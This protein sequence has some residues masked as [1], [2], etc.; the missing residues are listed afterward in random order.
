MTSAL[1]AGVITE[2]DVRIVFGGAVDWTKI[3]AGLRAR[4]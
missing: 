1:D 3:R 4:G 2:E